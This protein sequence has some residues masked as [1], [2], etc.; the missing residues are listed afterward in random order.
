MLVYIFFSCCGFSLQRSPWDTARPEPFLN[1]LAADLTPGWRQGG[2][3]AGGG[4]SS[5]WQSFHSHKCPKDRVVHFASTNVPNRWKEQEPRAKSQCDV[6]VWVMLKVLSSKKV[7]A[8]TALSL[9]QGFQ[10][11]KNATYNTA[12]CRCPL[13]TVESSSKALCWWDLYIPKNGNTWR[14]WL[15]P[16]FLQFMTITT[17]SFLVQTSSNVG[18]VWR[19]EET[20]A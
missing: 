4:H 14:I 19:K 15:I 3:L 16:F 18:S 10:P 12:C 7:L 9:R 11:R 6:L 2:L 8:M 13:W 5:R 1:R 17:L 20:A